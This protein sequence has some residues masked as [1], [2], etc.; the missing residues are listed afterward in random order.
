LLH[1]LGGDIEVCA[2]I[3][4][5]PIGELGA[6]AASFYPSGMTSSIGVTGDAVSIFTPIAA[7]AHSLVVALR[8]AG[9]AWSG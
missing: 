1:E 4:T 2:S 7:M 9:D 3:P 8:G 6:F 5:P